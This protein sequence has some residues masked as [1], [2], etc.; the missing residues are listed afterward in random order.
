MRNLRKFKD[1]LLED[2]KNPEYARVYLSVALE[3][4]EKDKNTAAF[5]TAVR[6]IAKANGGLTKLAERTHLNRQNLYKALSEEGNPSFGTIETVLQGLGY[7][8]SV[9][10]IKDDGVHYKRA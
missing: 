6:D 10:P 9:E 7:R 8:L 4:Y 3:E 5:L 2:L 1:T